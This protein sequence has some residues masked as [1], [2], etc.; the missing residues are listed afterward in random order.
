MKFFFGELFGGVAGGIDD[1]YRMVSTEDRDGQGVRPAGI[2]ASLRE[3]PGAGNQE[4]GLEGTEHELY[5]AFVGGRERTWRRI[6]D[7]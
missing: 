7:T 5:G 2:G 1:P 6:G 4:G 3:A